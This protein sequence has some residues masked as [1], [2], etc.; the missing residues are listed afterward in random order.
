MN[1]CNNRAIC[2]FVKAKFQRGG[3][4]V[5][6]AMTALVF[7]MLLFGTIDFA[8]LTYDRGTLTRA[9]NMAARQGSLYWV[10]VTN[11]DANAPNPAD[12]IMIDPQ[13]ITTVLDFFGDLMINP[14]N[15]ID[16]PEINILRIT[17]INDD[18][19]IEK[20][21]LLSTALPDK[22]ED[23]LEVKFSYPQ[24]FIVRLS[25]GGRESVVFSA[26][27]S[28]VDLNLDLK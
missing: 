16:T 6:F 20:K 25:G 19:K 23:G 13:K 28:E 12:N 15:I 7:F 18:Y 21:P 11:F 3:S 4:M 9:A 22:Q 2:R 1:F 8:L 14:A 27:L 17:K 24:Q 10:D 5:E 26:S